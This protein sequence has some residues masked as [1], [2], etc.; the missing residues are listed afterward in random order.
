MKSNSY[1]VLLIVFISIQISSA[2]DIAPRDLLDD[3]KALLSQ[4]NN[5][6]VIAFNSALENFRHYG[7]LGLDSKSTTAKRDGATDITKLS[8]EQLTSLDQIKNAAAELGLNITRC[9]DGTESSLN[10]LGEIEINN[11][12]ECVDAQKDNTLYNFNAAERKVRNIFRRVVTVTEMLDSCK[13]TDQV[14]INA[15]ITILDSDT[16]KV[17]HDIDQELATMNSTYNQ[18]TSFITDCIS[19]YVYDIT[20]KGDNILNSIRDC[21]ITLQKLHYR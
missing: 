9:L 16:V 3:A 20:D 6:S 11:I 18:G 2:R 19:T 12:D 1:I 8:D 13:A 21:V 7:P 17:P 14:C 5:D 10:Q 4:I 15:V